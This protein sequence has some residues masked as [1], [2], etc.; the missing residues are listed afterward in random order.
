MTDVTL[1]RDWGSGDWEHPYHMLT[2]DGRD[3]PVGT[4]VTDW[5]IAGREMFA[6]PQDSFGKVIRPGDIPG[7]ADLMEWEHAD[8]YWND[9]GYLFVNLRLT[10]YTLGKIM[11]ELSGLRVLRDIL[12]NLT[13]ISLGVFL[14]FYLRIRRRWLETDR[15]LAIAVEQHRMNRD[16]TMVRCEECPRCGAPR[17]EDSRFCAYCGENLIVLD[18]EESTDLLRKTMREGGDVR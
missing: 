3:I 11:P 15:E 4:N 12:I 13:L 17:V 10:P 5:Y 8:V 1:R 2:A 6:V 7:Y 18:S 14:F 16:G 9:D